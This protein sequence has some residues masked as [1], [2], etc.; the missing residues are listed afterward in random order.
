MCEH[1]TDPTE[2]YKVITEQESIKNNL[3]PMHAL[4]LHIH[5]PVVPT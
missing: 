2:W 5:V 1:I 4:N 3:R